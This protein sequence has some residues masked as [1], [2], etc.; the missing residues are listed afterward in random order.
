LRLAAVAL[1][2]AAAALTP[3]SAA[4]RPAVDWTRTVA[5][6]PS[7]GFR[8]GNPRA[9]VQLVEYG[10][11]TCPHCQHFDADGVGPLIAKYVKSGKVSYEFRSYLRNVFDLAA[12]MIAQCNGPKSFFPLTR[13]LLKD[14]SKW[15]AT[16]EKAPRSTLDGLLQLKE[17]RIPVAAARIAGLDAWAVR[18]GLPKVKVNQ[19]LTDGKAVDHLVARTAEVPNEFPEFA[20]TPSFLINGQ[21]QGSTTTWADLEPKLRAALGERG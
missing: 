13:A 18:H 15:I 21:L 8:M 16:A 4:P 17:D 1:A 7:G 9:K 14:Q 20:G 2:V 3:A 19:C 5:L 10:S 11:M 12:T 6:Q